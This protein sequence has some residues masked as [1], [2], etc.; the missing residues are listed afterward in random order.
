M[1]LGECGAAGAKG[2]DGGAL[3]GA[4]ACSVMW[5]A[6]AFFFAQVSLH[7]KQCVETQESVLQ[8]SL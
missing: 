2:R 5:M 8:V 3:R 6:Q 1:R 7:H 4:V